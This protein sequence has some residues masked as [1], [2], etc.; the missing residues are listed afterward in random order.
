MRWPQTYVSRSS[1]GSQRRQPSLQKSRTQILKV[2]PGWTWAQ[3]LATAWNRLQA[4]H[5]G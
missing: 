5:P 2:P 1:R 3:D 4:L